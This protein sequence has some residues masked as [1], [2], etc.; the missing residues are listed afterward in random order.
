MSRRTCIASTLIFIYAKLLYDVEYAY[1][2]VRLF[3]F[4]LVQIHFLYG[5]NNSLN[6]FMFEFSVNFQHMHKS[7]YVTDRF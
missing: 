6:F 7:K 1:V 5:V 2:F 3:V 4:F